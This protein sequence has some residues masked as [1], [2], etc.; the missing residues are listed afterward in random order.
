MDKSIIYATLVSGGYRVEQYS[1]YD[2]SYQGEYFV[3]Q[4]EFTSYKNN[5]QYIIKYR[6]TY[7][8]SYNQ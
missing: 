8:F 4:T 2:D 1:D 7:A 5:P 3:T 6:Q